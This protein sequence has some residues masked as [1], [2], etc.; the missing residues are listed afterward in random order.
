MSDCPI[1]YVYLYAECGMPAKVVCIILG[2][3][4]FKDAYLIILET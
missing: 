4:I 3:N 2:G 1:L